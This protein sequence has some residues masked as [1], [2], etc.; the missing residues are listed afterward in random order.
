MSK[1]AGSQPSDGVMGRPPTLSIVTI[2]LN[3]PAG[4]GR[5]LDSTRA[6]RECSGVEHVVVDAGERAVIPDDGRVRVVAQAARGIAAAFNLGLESARGE[7]VWFLN[8][9][10][11]AHESVSPEW[12]LTLLGSTGAD[13]VAASLH[14]DGEERPRRQPHVSRQWPL[15]ACWLAHPAT[16]VRREGLIAAGGFH[17][18]WKIAMDYDLWFRLLKRETVVDVISVPLARFDVTG[19]SQRESGRRQAGAEDAGVILTH[20]CGLFTEPVWA[21]AHV[22]RRVARAGFRWLRGASH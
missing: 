8:G 22:L 21:L 1:N 18:R 15:I 6:W 10:D 19:I 2:T 14:F 3:D 13:V 20:A 4:L 9:G 11:A 12:L 7:W 5:T 17:Q 16:I